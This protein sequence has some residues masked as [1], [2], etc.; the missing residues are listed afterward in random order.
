MAVLRKSSGRA[1]DVTELAL[2]AGDRWLVSQECSPPRHRGIIGAKS[3]T[4]RHGLVMG[5]LFTS[6]VEALYISA[7]GTFRMQ[8]W[9]GD[10]RTTAEAAAAV[11]AWRYPGDFYKLLKV[12]LIMRRFDR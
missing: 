8:W 1:C 6:P 3:A 10:P 5:F 4:A 11:A 7:G 9:A 2:A 12:K